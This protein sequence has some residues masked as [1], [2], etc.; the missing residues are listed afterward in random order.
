MVIRIGGRIFDLLLIKIELRALLIVLNANDE[1]HCKLEPRITRSKN[2]V[3]SSFDKSMIFI[4]KTDL[5]L[6]TDLQIKLSF[7]VDLEWQEELEAG[8]LLQMLQFLVTF[9]LLEVEVEEF[10]D[11]GQDVG[12]VSR[13]SYSKLAFHF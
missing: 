1:K 8:E 10:I 13:S 5:E 12:C 3:S 6:F 2:R 7:L 4:D 11:A 9:H